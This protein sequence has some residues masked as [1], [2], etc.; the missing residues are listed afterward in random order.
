[1]LRDEFVGLASRLGFVFR[2]YEYRPPLGKNK[3]P[4][5]VAY[6]TKSKQVIRWMEEVGSIKDGILNVTDIGKC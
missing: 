3:S 6:T 1:M 5:Q 2:Y 4:L